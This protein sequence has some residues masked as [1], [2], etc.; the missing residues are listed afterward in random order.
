MSFLYKNS[1]KIFAYADFPK[2]EAHL[3]C[4][5]LYNLFQLIRQISNQLCIRPV[6][7]SEHIRFLPNRLLAFF[8]LI[9]S[10]FANV[11]AAVTW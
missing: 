6:Y 7:R 3:G 1:L 2:S 8:H 5:S 10:S 4:L 11:N 9:A